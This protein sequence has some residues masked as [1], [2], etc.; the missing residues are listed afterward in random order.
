M[1]PIVAYAANKLP[2]FLELPVVRK[3]IS[4]NSERNYNDKQEL[5]AFVDSIRPSRTVDG[6]VGV[7]CSCGKQY[8]YATEAEVPASNLVCSQCSRNLIVYGN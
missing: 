3:R 4:E 1:K 7:T 5:V 2:M 8:D 6:Y